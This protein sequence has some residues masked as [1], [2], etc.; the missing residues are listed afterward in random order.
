MHRNVATVTATLLTAV[1]AAGCAALAIG[2]AGVDLGPVSRLGPGGGQAVIPAAIAFTVATL[3]LA[4]IAWG[5]WCH[6][7]WAWSAGLVLHGLIVV[8]AAVPFRGAGS[9][10]GIV[11]A[12]AAAATLLSPQARN[13]LLGR[14]AA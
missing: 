2:H 7:A 9:L 14:R 4:V 3:A 1:L 5:L 11:L 10:A 6:R 13:A 8:S 12:G